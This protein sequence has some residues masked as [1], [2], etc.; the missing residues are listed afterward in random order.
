VLPDG[1]CDGCYLSAL[2][3]GHSSAFP[4]GDRFFGG[5]GIEVCFIRCPS[6]GS[7]ITEFRRGRL[8]QLDLQP[9]EDSFD[10]QTLA[11]RHLPVALRTP[12]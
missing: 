3:P 10:R 12:L 6:P 5:F 4:V 9:V 7:Y 11:A 8:H 2:V 1:T